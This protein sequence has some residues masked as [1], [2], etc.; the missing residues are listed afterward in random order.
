[1]GGTGHDVTR[2]LVLGGGGVAGI[3]WETGV[4]LG[5]F[6]AGVDLAGADRVIGTSAGSAVAAQITSGVP[7]VELFARQVSPDGMKHEIA[8]EF[9]AEQMMT[10]FGRILSGVK[11]G[12]EMNKAI[13]D[14]ALK[15]STVAEP[16]RRDVIAARLP[17]RSWPD[18]DLQIVAVDAASGEPR[19]F[20]SGDVDLVD[21]VAA[22]CA[23]PGIWPPV[24][25]EG[26]R[27]IDGGMRSA[28]NA[29]LATGC[30]DVLVIAPMAEL[31]MVA[32]DVKQRIDELERVARVVT[33]RPDE[34]STAAMGMNPLDP[35]TARPSAEAGRVQAAAHVAEVAALWSAR[36]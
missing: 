34:A 16:L 23:V 17:S 26:R 18:R 20:A 24:S 30:D 7:L 25:I 36:G 22:S 3:A 12:I 2:A 1:M 32:P 11:P 6:D 5:L 27:Y 35:S 14:Y 9:D 19:V 10:E 13:G 29:D 33:I 31:P 28:S 15:A 8:A 4:L 21:A